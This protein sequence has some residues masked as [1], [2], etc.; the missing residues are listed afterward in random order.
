M[1]KVLNSSHTPYDQKIKTKFAL[2][3]QGHNGEPGTFLTYMM[4]GNPSSTVLKLA[5]Y[6]G[7]IISFFRPKTDK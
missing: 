4:R 7:H 1:C 2:S 3:K 6:S 5:T